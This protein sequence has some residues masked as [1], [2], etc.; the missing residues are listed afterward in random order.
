MLTPYGG[1]VVC[2]PT[3]A[4]AP[5]GRVPPV[6]VTSAEFGIT[7]FSRFMREH[8]T[9]L[10][11]ASLNFRSTSARASPLAPVPKKPRSVIRNPMFSINCL[12]GLSFGSRIR[13][14]SFCQHEFVI[15]S[16]NNIPSP[17]K[18][19]ACLPVVSKPLNPR[20]YAV[21]FRKYIFDL[22]PHIGILS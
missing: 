9:P 8:G 14:P 18:H 21:A 1:E 12:V 4:L 10:S 17:V 2:R 3:A 11:S 22:N 6:P 20:G 5:Y 13:G 15:S 7:W 16:E 19:L